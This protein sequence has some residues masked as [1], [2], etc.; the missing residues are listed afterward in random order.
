MHV[1]EMADPSFSRRRA[2]PGIRHSIGRLVMLTQDLRDRSGLVENE[3]VVKIVVPHVTDGTDVHGVRAV[4][5][6]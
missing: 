1:A 6:V 5:A 4:A 2:N 3:S